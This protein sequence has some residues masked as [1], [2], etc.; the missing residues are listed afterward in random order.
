ME[1][2]RISCL[3]L[4]IFALAVLMNS[5]HYWLEIMENEKARGMLN[6]HRNALK[7]PVWNVGNYDFYV[8]FIE[9]EHDNAIC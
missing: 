2:T 8:Y 7:T 4:V 9:A 5:I 6:N 3:L 1:E